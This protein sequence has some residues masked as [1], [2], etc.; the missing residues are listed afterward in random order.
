ML[1]ARENTLE[2]IQFGH[3]DRVTGGIPGYG[4]SYFGINHESWDGV[5]EDCPAGTKWIDTWGVG[6]EKVHDGVMGLPKLNPLAEIGALKNYRWPDPDDERICGII[7]KQAEAFRGGD[8][9]ISGGHR[10][11]LFE[12]AYM[13]VGMENLFEYFFS[14]PEYVLEIFHRITDFNIGIQKHYL[15]NGI[16]AANLGDDLGCQTGP[17]ISPDYVKEFMV[18]EYKRLMST[19]T[20]KGV[21]INFHSCGKI[22]KFLD[23]FMDLGINV[24]NPLQATA[25]NLDLVREK[26]LGRMALQGGVSSALVMDGPPE[27]IREA[28]RDAIQKLGKQGGYFCTPDQGMPFPEE[29]LKVFTRAVEE[30]GKYPV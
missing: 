13:L 6:W 17:I 16:E 10:D 23:I 15:A 25:N 24:L 2:I 21:I 1:G 19:Y 29:H 8:V 20:E 7:Y 11:T 27:K 9:F 12:K 30:Y 22:E 28:V 14:E 18:P 4:I 26:T 5:T 3:P